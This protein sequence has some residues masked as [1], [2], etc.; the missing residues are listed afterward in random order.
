IHLRRGREQQGPHPLAAADSGMAHGFYQAHPE[1]RWNG[2]Q[3]VEQAID[4]PLYPNQFVL[5][6]AVDRS[7]DRVQSAVPNGSVPTG[8][9]PPPD[10]IFSIRAWAA[11]SLAWQCW[12]SSSP[13]SYSSIESSSGTSPLSSLRTTS[14]RARS[15]SSK[16]MAA[17]SRACSSIRASIDGPK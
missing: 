8:L 4:F 14:S 7:H 9:P 3:G 2:E 16:L 15:A 10:T 6:Q 5:Q 11:S 12:R 17:M 1:I 13:R